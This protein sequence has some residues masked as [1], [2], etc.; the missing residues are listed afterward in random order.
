M[1]RQGSLSGPRGTETR[2]VGVSLR[3]PLRVPSA[4]STTASAAPS[5]NAD[6]ADGSY[7][8]DASV[9]YKTV[10]SVNAT[11]R[12]LSLYNTRTCTIRV[13]QYGL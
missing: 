3:Q 7:E 12:I 13:N 11:P 5:M 4:A 6:E 1:D 8:G 10:R 9:D 2:P